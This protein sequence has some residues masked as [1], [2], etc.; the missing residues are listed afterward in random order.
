MSDL[1]LYLKLNDLSRQVEAIES[2]LGAI[3]ERLDKIERRTNSNG[4]KLPPPRR[5]SEML[6]S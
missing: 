1:R 3:L 4:V 5:Y 2:D 6:K